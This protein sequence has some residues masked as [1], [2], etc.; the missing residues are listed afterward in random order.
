MRKASKYTALVLALLASLTLVA[1]YTGTPKVVV[2]DPGNNNGGGGNGGGASYPGCNESNSGAS[3][4]IVLCANPKKIQRAAQKAL[5]NAEPGDTIVFPA[6]KYYFTKS[7]QITNTPNIT[8]KG[9][10]EDKK[11]KTIL[12]FS[13]M[14]GG[15]LA[16]VMIKTGKV[17]IKDLQILNSPTDG[18][19]V[20]GPTDD[21]LDQVT[22]DHVHVEWNIPPNYSHGGYGFYPVRS[23]NILIQN[24]TCIG[25]EDA[26]IYVGQSKNI[27]IR[28]TTVMRSVVGLELES[29]THADVYNNISHDNSVGMLFYA[30]AGLPTHFAKSDYRAWNNKIYHNNTPNFGGGYAGQAP[31]G[32]GIMILSDNHIELFDN[33][34]H[35]NQAV[36]IALINY[37]LLDSNFAPAPLGSYVHD[38]SICDSDGNCNIFDPYVRAIYL[39]DNTIYGGG[40]YPA[41]PDAYSQGAIDNG[42]LLMALFPS[43]PIPDIIWTRLIDPMYADS[44]NQ[45]QNQADQ[46]ICFHN[47]KGQESKDKNGNS[48]YTKV[49]YSDLTIAGQTPPKIEAGSGFHAC[50]GSKL[51]LRQ[52]KVKLPQMQ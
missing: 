39:H 45:N 31:T 43:R 36:N 2:N 48:T 33:E 32:T 30:E 1:C 49:T 29:S 52:A 18:I 42:Q 19:R 24:S 35:G 9:T 10:R 23:K 38:P 51:N 34:I 15:G 50:D 4:K 46:K 40:Y 17:K 44:N 3:D 7:L 37:G 21:F 22:F 47:N 20:Q 14:T 41:D 12:D 25:S 5:D 6:G 28:N 27:V 8:I 26:C 13:G 16:A 11:N